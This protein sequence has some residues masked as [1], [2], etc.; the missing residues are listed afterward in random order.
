MA[1]VVE[2]DRKSNFSKVTAPRCRRVRYLFSW[3]TPF[4]P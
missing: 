2:S 1:T 3:V 4:Y